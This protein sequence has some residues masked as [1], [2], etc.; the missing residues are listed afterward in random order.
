MVFPALVELNVI[1]PVALQTVAA[2][3]DMEPL[4]AIVPVLEKV[5]VPADTVML[6]QV[7]APVKVT[8]YVAAW[9]KITLSA[10]VGTDAPEPPPEDEDQLVVDEVFHVPV[11]PTQYLFAMITPQSVRQP[12]AVGW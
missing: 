1:V 10:A 4:T 12:Q 3:N 2:T 6:K 9:S 11:P 8:V 7:N 5:T